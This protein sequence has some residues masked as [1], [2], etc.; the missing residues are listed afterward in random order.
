MMI[1]FLCLKLVS[2][3]CIEAFEI[4]PQRLLSFSDVTLCWWLL[5]PLAS[6]WN[7]GWLSIASPQNEGLKLRWIDF[8]TRPWRKRS[9]DRS[10]LIPANEL[11]NMIGAHAKDLSDLWRCEKSDL[12]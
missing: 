9:I 12:P 2:S 6:R 1:K 5:L 10:K 3:R 4:T 7:G 8:P 11:D